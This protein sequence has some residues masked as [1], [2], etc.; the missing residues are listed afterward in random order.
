MFGLGRETDHRIDCSFFP[1]SLPPIFSAEAQI[2]GKISR[3]ELSLQSS[4][5]SMM[6]GHNPVEKTRIHL[7]ISFSR[8]SMKCARL[9]ARLRLPQLKSKF[10][11]FPCS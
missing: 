5:A 1:P 6:V 2:Y 9:A 4:A 3:G 8:E 10:L 11:D 7:L